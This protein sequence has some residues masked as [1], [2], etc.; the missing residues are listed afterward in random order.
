MNLEAL[1]LTHDEFLALMSQWRRG[2][3]GLHVTVNMRA[4]ELEAFLTPHEINLWRF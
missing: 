3:K 4:Q 1:P 2:S